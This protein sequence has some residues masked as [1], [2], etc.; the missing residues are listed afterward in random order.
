MILNVP[1]LAIRTPHS[2]QLTPCTSPSGPM[3]RDAATGTP[4][5]LATSIAHSASSTC[6]K[7]CAKNNIYIISGHIYPDNM[8]KVVMFL[9]KYSK[10][11]FNIKVVSVKN[12]ENWCDYIHFFNTLEC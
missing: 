3:H 9:R 1:A 10:N 4:V 6:S 11:L 2:P 12:S 8:H 7:Y 5:S